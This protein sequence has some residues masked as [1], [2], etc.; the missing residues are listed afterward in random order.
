MEADLG[1]FEGV[2]RGERLDERQG[3]PAGIGLG[4]RGS[5]LGIAQDQTVHVLHHVELRA[6]HRLVFAQGRHRRH[7]HCTRPESRHDAVFPC[8]VVG[9][10]QEAANRRAAQDVEG[11]IGV[12]DAVGQVR[13]TSTDQAEVQ[14]WLHAGHLLAQPELNLGQVDTGQLTAGVVDDLLLLPGHWVL[15]VPGSFL[16]LAIKSQAS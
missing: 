3:R 12:G 15:V 9:A 8:Q 1:R 10:R 6:D 4:Q 16:A 7:G 11:A 14:G 2:D 5:G 13:A